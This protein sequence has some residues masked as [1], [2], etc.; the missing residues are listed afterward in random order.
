MW[1]KYPNPHCSHVVTVDVVDRSVDP[2][3]GVIRTERILGCK[4]RAPTWIV[5]VWYFILLLSS[6]ILTYL[7]Q[8]FGGS[9]DAFVR[10]ISFIDP[11]TQ[12]ATISSVNLTLSQFATCNESIRYAP[13]V[14]GQTSFSQTAEIQAR[15]AMW[16]AA[17]DKLENWL[18]N[19]FEQ[20]AQLGKV[21]FTDVLRRLWEDAQD[22][23]PAHAPA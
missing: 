6:W 13:T 23:K 7:L 8:L 12:N 14:N 9:E 18:A 15:M 5:K 17:A 3:T 21:A 19:R 22:S 4:Q 11:S 10:E 20:N 1:H 16:R 2:R